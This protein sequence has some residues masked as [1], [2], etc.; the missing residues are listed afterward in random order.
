MAG[1]Q[2]GGARPLLYPPLFLSAQTQ[3]HGFKYH[4][5]AD[6]SQ[7]CLCSP[8]LSSKVQTHIFYCFLIIFMKVSPGHL[9]LSMS[10]LNHDVPLSQ[11]T[12]PQSSPFYSWLRPPF[13]PFGLSH[14]TSYP[15]SKYFGSSF[16]FISQI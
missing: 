7:M 4:L 1:S 11:P 6:G 9:K 14:H 16:K 8:V 13:I 2:K 15:S 12:H 3:A 10:T 5:R